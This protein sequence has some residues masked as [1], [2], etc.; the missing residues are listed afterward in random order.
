MESYQLDAL[1]YY[2]AQ[3]LAF[4]AILK[5]SSV[6]LELFTNIDKKFVD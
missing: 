3:G 4:D 6:K 5:Y 2:T 1:R